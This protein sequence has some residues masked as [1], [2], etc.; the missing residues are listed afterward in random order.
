MIKLT[1]YWCA[2]FELFF[3]L[4]YGSDCHSILDMVLPATYKKNNCTYFSSTSE[5][6]LEKFKNTWAER[7]YNKKKMSWESLFQDILRMQQSDQNL[8]PKAYGMNSY[9]LISL[10]TSTI[11]KRFQR[12]RKVEQLFTY[13]DFRKYIAILTV[14]YRDSEYDLGIM[15]YVL[16]N[17]FSHTQS[18]LIKA[19]TPPDLIVKEF[20]DYPDFKCLVQKRYDQFCELNGQLKP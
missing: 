3:D 1:M 17:L 4:E 6:Y 19:G 2:I 5:Q 9:E 11:K 8:T 16:V 14:P 12:W 20:S 7:K 18:N 15:I 13:E 10:D